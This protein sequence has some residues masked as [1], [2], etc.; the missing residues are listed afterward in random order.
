MKNRME[1]ITTTSY[2]ICLYSVSQL[3]TYMK[4]I[5]KGRQK[6]LLSFFQKN[7]ET[8]LQSLA[9]GAWLPI[10]RI[11]S[12]GYTVKVSNSCESFDDDWIEV[13]SYDGF[14][15]RIGDDNAVWIAS[16]GKLL[17]FDENE[18]VNSANGILAYNTLDGETIK[19][20]IRYNIDIGD[21]T[22]SI[23]GYRSKNDEK[24]G[25]LFTFE[26]VSGPLEIKDP[27]CDEI[28]DFNKINR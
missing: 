3:K 18:H 22:V 1:T 28:Y 11:N 2:G 12:I 4:K 8:Y 16:I 23:K 20:A 10:V 27:R 6:K 13:Y 24:R 25:F 21:Y 5:G 19:S 15:L 26:K 17:N 7:Q 9:E 14:Y